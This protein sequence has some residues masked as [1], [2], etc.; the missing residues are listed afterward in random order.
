M[1]RVQTIDG[2]PVYDAKE[3][4]FIE[5]IADDIHPK[6]RKNPGKCAMAEACKRELRVTEARAYLSRLYVKHEDHWLRYALGEAVRAEVASFD[7]GGGFSE[8]V[9]RLTPKPLHQQ[10]GGKHE[11][12]SGIHAQP[13]KTKRQTH[14]VIKGVR[15]PSPLFGG[16]LEG[17]H[18]K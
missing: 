7:R 4:L 12:G 1:K 10:A 3:P 14:R 11:G 5:V 2:L 17:P 15:A 13:R 6:D 16:A 18:N 8:G 9:Y